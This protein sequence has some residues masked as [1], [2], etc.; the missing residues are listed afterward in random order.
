MSPSLVPDAIV[1]NGASGSG[2]SSIARLLQEGLPE[3]FLNFSI[4]AIL[5]AIPPTDLA[6]MVAGEPIRTAGYRYEK[7]VWGYHAAAAALL[8]T[9]NRL[10]LDNAITRVDWRLDLERR[11]D[12]YRAV[13]VG[14]VCDAP[15]LA[16]RGR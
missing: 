2:K 15:E 14:L 3:V 10:I 8:A 9:G 7:L 11:L 12:G 6:K 5:Y 4:D 16:K 1:L 13:W